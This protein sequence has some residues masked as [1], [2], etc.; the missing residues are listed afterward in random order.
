[1]NPIAS[2]LRSW[3]ERLRRVDANLD[4]EVDL[5]AIDQAEMEAIQERQAANRNLAF[6][7]S[8]PSRYANASYATLRPEQDPNGL[9]SRWL[10]SGPRS[11][12]IAGPSRT[13]KTTA[14]YAIAN[15][16]H[17]RGIWVLV[18][19]ATSLAA[20]LKPE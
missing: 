17:E 1:M 8:R 13:G 20:A 4:A 15:D 2:Q 10:D 11:L 6:I 9:V 5:D 14:A 16:A 3:Q 18:R 19:T 7:R 12:L